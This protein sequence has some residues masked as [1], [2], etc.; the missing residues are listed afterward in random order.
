MKIMIESASPDE[1]G[2]QDFETTRLDHVLLCEEL[3]QVA[4]VL[5][6]EVYLLGWHG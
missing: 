5:D 3:G 2:K 4:L 6:G 1:I